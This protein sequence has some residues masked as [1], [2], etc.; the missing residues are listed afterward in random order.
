VREKPPLWFV[1]VPFTK[2]LSEYVKEKKRKKE[3]K[4]ERKKSTMT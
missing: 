4:K 1:F 2:N 3:R